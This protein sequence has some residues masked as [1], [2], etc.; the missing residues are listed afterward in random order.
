M[1]SNMLFK[2]GNVDIS[3]QRVDELHLHQDSNKIVGDPR[4]GMEEVEDLRAIGDTVDSVLADD[5]S[6]RGGNES[7]VAG[8]LDSYEGGEVPIPDMH[9][10]RDMFDSSV[11]LCGG[12]WAAH[13]LLVRPGMSSSKC[14]S[15]RYVIPV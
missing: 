8:K 13:D 9:D 11:S 3:I 1:R 10:G 2:D 5:L 7:R 15:T 12:I 6:Q 14:G 4:D